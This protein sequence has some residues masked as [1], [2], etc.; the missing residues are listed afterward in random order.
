MRVRLRVLENGTRVRIRR[1][2]PGERGT[3]IVGG[4]VTGSGVD[5]PA[6]ELRHGR[7]GRP[8]ILR[9]SRLR[10]VR[11]TTDLPARGSSD[12][13][14]HGPRLP[15]WVR[16]TTDLPGSGSSNRR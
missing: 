16:V 2:G 11:A 8:R 1:P 6:Y 10:L 3:W 12:T 4:R 14:R 5:D 9:R 7:S 15:E 13:D